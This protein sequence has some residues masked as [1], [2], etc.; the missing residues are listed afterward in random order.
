MHHTGTHI[1]YYFIC[2]RKLWF[3]SNGIQVEHTSNLV[4]KDIFI[5]E[6]YYS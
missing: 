4:N 5:Y 2:Q 6:I 3:F 1:N